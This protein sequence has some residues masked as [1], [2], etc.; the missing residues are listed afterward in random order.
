MEGSAGC[1]ANQLNP[2][3]AN[4]DLPLL[5]TDEDLGNGAYLNALERDGFDVVT[6]NDAAT[7]GS[8]DEVHLRFA[9]G[10][11]RALISQNVGD[12]HGLHVRWMAD[13][14]E[15]WGI[16]LIHQRH[17]YGPGRGGAPH[18]VSCP[19]T[20]PGGPAELARLPQR[21]LR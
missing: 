17:R 7:A 3:A 2:A 8:D 12:F 6:A 15:H 14:L 11:E 19:R 5:Y 1:G 20:R 16:I 4:D 10:L 18:G 13:G 21:L 9:V